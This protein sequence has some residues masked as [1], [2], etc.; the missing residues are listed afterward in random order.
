MVPQD[1]FELRS[2]APPNLD[3]VERGVGKSIARVVRDALQPELRRRI[4]SAM[5]F[6]ERIGQAYDVMGERWQ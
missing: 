6:Q 1:L 3:K 5:A 4:D 2:A